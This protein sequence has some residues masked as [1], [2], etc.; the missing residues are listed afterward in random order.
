MT[1]KSVRQETSLCRQSILSDVVMPEEPRYVGMQHM[2]ESVQFD[3][4]VCALL[5]TYT[6]QAGLLIF[7]KH[8]CTGH[9]DDFL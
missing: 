3:Y 6:E 7:K 9:I 1:H 2:L 4:K 5:L 8:W